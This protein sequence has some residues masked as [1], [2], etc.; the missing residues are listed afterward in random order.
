MCASISEHV[1]VCVCVQASLGSGVQ[2]NTHQNQTSAE[3]SHKMPSHR[4]FVI[5]EPHFKYA[6]PSPCSQEHTPDHAPQNCAPRKQWLSRGAGCPHLWHGQG[7]QAYNSRLQ[8]LPDV[9]HQEA[10]PLAVPQ[11]LG[12]SRAGRTGSWGL[13]LEV[14]CSTAGGHGACGAT[15][16]GPGQG[17]QN[18]QGEV[19]LV[20]WRRLLGECWR[21]LL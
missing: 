7:K 4:E 16:L 13:E 5:S 9:P 20:F 1:C 6:P 17:R 10:M 14:R 11:H 19:G 8:R 3:L 18:R 2:P 15:A 21:N 12:L